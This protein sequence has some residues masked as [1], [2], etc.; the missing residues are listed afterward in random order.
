MNKKST[1]DLLQ[2]LHLN[3]TKDQ[4]A[5]ANCVRWYGHALSIPLLLLLLERIIRTL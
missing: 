2:M 1:K 3:D 4:L 5:R